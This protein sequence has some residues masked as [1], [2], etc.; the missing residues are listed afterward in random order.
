MI[1]SSKEVSPEAFAW[2]FANP[3]AI[4]TIAKSSKVPPHTSKLAQLF[5]INL[6]TSSRRPLNNGRRLIHDFIDPG[7]ENQFLATSGQG[8]FKVLEGRAPKGAL[9]EAEGIER[10]L[11][12]AFWQ[13]VIS[14]EA[15]LEGASQ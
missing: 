8:R 5:R 1:F 6:Q 9:A 13:R 4:N 3:P 10:S 2:G 14:A 12:R 7:R 15:K 11:S